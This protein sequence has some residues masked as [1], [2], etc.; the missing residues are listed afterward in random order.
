MASSA[1]SRWSGVPHRPTAEERAMAEINAK[2]QQI[3]DAKKTQRDHIKSTMIR[4]RWEGNSRAET[5]FKDLLQSYDDV[6]QGVDEMNKVMENGIRNCKEHIH[7]LKSIQRQF[8]T[9][10]HQALRIGGHGDLFDHMKEII[11]QYDDAEQRVI[12]LNIGIE[13]I[14][15][16][17]LAP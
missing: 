16:P 6:E 10:L 11:E 3:K 4:M 15:S 2:V 9:S 1:N 7:R 8:F 17:T 14:K 5:L 12:D 13:R